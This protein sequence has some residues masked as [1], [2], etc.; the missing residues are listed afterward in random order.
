MELGIKPDNFDQAAR[1][2]ISDIIDAMG[3]DTSRITV[4]DQPFEGCNPVK[5]FKFFDSPKAI[6]VNRDPRDHYLLAKKYMRPRGDGYQIPCDN[7]DDYIKFYRLIHKSPPD[8]KDRSD[9]LFI[10]FEELVYDYENAAKKIMDFAGITKHIHKGK[11]FKPNHSRNNTQ[12]FKKFT[13]L[14]TDIK[15]IEQE[16]QEY[17][18]PFENYPD[19]EPKGKMFYHNPVKKQTNGIKNA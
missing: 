13:G 10:N 14:E 15:K 18:F 1:T 11:Y 4:L 9:I 7:A 8:L 3:R 17:L 5:S 6:V 19:I 16:L 2:F 12:L